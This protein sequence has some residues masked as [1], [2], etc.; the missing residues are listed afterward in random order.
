MVIG[1][2][3]GR[4]WAT[5]KDEKLNGQKFL[6]VR[7]LKDIDVEETG[8]FVAADSV[9]AGTGDNVLITRGGAARV[10]LGERDVPVDATIIGIIDSIEVENE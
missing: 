1:R 3:V 2:V 8:F 6:I 4:L 7:L 10:S 5:R 9:G